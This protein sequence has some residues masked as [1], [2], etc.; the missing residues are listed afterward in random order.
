M[1]GERILND[2]LKKKLD[3]LYDDTKNYIATLTRVLEP[4][5]TKNGYQY[6]A[7]GCNT[8]EQIVSKY[9]TFCNKFLRCAIEA[10]KTAKDG[11]DLRGIMKIV[12][13]IMDV[14]DLVLLHDN[15]K[16]HKVVPSLDEI[17]T[18]LYH[19]A[20]QLITKN[21]FDLSMDYI[22]YFIKYM[23]LAKSQ[24]KSCMNELRR[25]AKSMASLCW[26]AAALLEQ[27]CKGSPKTSGY[28]NV[29]KWRLHGV[30]LDAEA[31]SEA[32]HCLITKAA[33]SVMKFR[34][35]C[36]SISIE[37][38][39]SLMSQLTLSFDTLMCQLRQQNNRNLPELRHIFSLF[40]LGLLISRLFHTM[41]KAKDAFFMLEKL[42]NFI[43]EMLKLVKS[44][45]AESCLISRLSSCCI[46][47]TKATIQLDEVL[48]KTTA[49]SSSFE[50]LDKLLC[51]GHKALELL[52]SMKDV[53]LHSSISQT[54]EHMK[55]FLQPIISKENKD[56]PKKTFHYL[57]LLFDVYTNMLNTE[58]ETFC[59]DSQHKQQYQK[60]VA[61]YLSVCTCVMNI[62]KHQIQ[63]G[64]NQKSTKE[65]DQMMSDC[66]QYSKQCSDVIK[67][68][69]ANCSVCSNDELMWHGQITCS[70][71]MEA[72]KHDAYDR[73]AELMMLGCSDMKQWCYLGK[74]SN[75][76]N[77]RL[78]QLQ[79]F[80]KYEALRDCQRRSKLY[81]E[82]FDTSTT[83]IELLLYKTQEVD[84]QS[85]DTDVQKY[86]QLWVQSKHDVIK[87]SGQ[88]DLPD[89]QKRTLLDVIEDSSHSV[90]SMDTCCLL[91]QELHCCKMLNSR[92]DTLLEQLSVTSQLI[93]IYREE[94]SF[95]LATALLEHMKI[96]HSNGITDQTP[97]NICQEA[98]TF[99]EAAINQCQGG[100]NP[101]PVVA[102]QDTLAKAYFWKG[103][104]QHEAVTRDHG[105]NHDGM[106]TE[107]LE[108]S[109]QAIS[110][111]QPFVL[112]LHAAVDMW[113]SMVENCLKESRKVEINLSNLSDPLETVGCLKT[114]SMLYG[115]LKQ[116]LNQVHA[117][118]LCSLVSQATD[119]TD[120][121]VTAIEA[122]TQSIYTLCNMHDL[123]H[124]QLIM[125]YCKKI[126]DETSLQSFS[127]VQLLIA[128]SHLH[129]E[130][131]QFS[132]G[133]KC[134]VK[135]LDSDVMLG[136]TSCNQIVIQAMAYSLLAKYLQIPHTIYKFDFSQGSSGSEMTPLDA[137]IESIRKLESIVKTHFTDEVNTD[138]K[139][140]SSGCPVISTD[141][142]LLLI[143][144]NLLDC[145]MQ[146]GDLMSHQG[147]VKQAIKYFTDGL[148]L[149][150]RMA[151]PYRVAEFVSNLCVTKIHKG[152]FPAAENHLLQVCH[153]LG[154]V[155]QPSCTITE[156]EHC[157]QVP[158]LIN[159][160]DTCCHV[161]CADPTI[162]SLQIA[163][164][165]KLSKYLESIQ[166]YRQSI[167][168]L[169]IADQ[170]ISHASQRLQCALDE[171]SSLL[172]LGTGRS[173]KPPS[174]SNK[175]DAKKKVS[176]R[177]QPCKL[178]TGEVSL[179]STIHI[180]YSSYLC[181]VFVQNSLILLGNGKVKKVLDVVKGGTDV[182][183][184][185]KAV[186]G[187]TPF[188][189]IPNVTHLLYLKGV[190]YILQELGSNDSAL[191]AL[192]YNNLVEADNKNSSEGSLDDTKVKRKTRG[193]TAKKKDVLP[194]NEEV[195]KVA[196]GRGRSKKAS[197]DKQ[198]QENINKDRTGNDG[199]QLAID[200]FIKAF[201]LCSCWPNPQL[202]SQLCQSLAF[203]YG[204]SEP[205]KTAY[206]L[207]LSLGITL[208][209]EAA[210]TTRTK[211]RK[212][213]KNI[214]PEVPGG[215]VSSLA[216]KLSSIT[217]DDSLDDSQTIIQSLQQTRQLMLFKNKPG[218]STKGIPKD[219]T[220]CT[221]VPVQLP[222]H[223]QQ[224][225]ISR[226]R[227][228]TRP[229]VV[230]VSMP[231]IVHEDDTFCNDQVNKAV[232]DLSQLFQGNIQQEFSDI[233]Q[234]S[235]DSM[236]INDDKDWQHARS[237]LDSRLKSLLER[238]E[239]AWLGMW[240]GIVLGQQYDVN[241]QEALLQTTK[242]LIVKLARYT[243]NSLDEEII[244]MIL[245]S[246]DYLTMSQTRDVLSMITGIDKTIPKLDQAVE[247]FQQAVSSL[248]TR[249]SGR[250][251]SQL[252]SDRHPVIL[253]LGK[254]IQ[255][256]P[257][258]NIPIL[259]Q[260]PITRMPSMHFVL[261]QTQK[262]EQSVDPVNAYFV[263]NPE[264][265]LPNTQKIFQNWFESELKW[266]G[267]SGEKPS[268]EQY[269]SA[270]SDHDLFLYLGHNAGQSFLG[271]DDVQRII[272]RATALLMGCS[273]AK[274]T[275]DGICEPRGM[276]LRYLL[277]GCPAIVGNLWDVTDRDIDRFTKFL[278]KA[279]L[280][281]GQKWSL[282]QF[283]RNA[284]Q[285]CKW[286]YLIGASPVV[287]GV[288]VF[289]KNQ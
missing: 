273:S 62:Y 150:R 12:N 212:L 111:E 79:L 18:K 45:T 47:L 2:L 78:Q 70:I 220:I 156:L 106:N 129:L 256:L 32:L 51:E 218:L 119:T 30:L 128:R 113:T 193:R 248:P 245:D 178:A 194:T 225:V 227:P 109:D 161:C 259:R 139:I 170:L 209:H 171:C 31:S 76:F 141:T 3:G 288:P 274:L 253:I 82:A 265:N 43:S 174:K 36:G 37:I 181:Q 56:N 97:L 154:P 207:D 241:Q 93:S 96:L 23:Q 240:K 168:A 95:C 183:E 201:N 135:A 83:M 22:E 235:L 121:S 189:L 167:T 60:I 252:T 262:G 195:E 68:L 61:K 164:F 14:L 80:I 123:H 117:N 38:D 98:I 166:H 250:K 118:H 20:S 1:E 87:H 39:S 155:L 276:S 176:K 112:S 180:M 8:I 230:K 74:N 53:S 270:L 244:Q 200:T 69:I 64:L 186:T 90:N 15:G 210:Y 206:Y 219:W 214:K 278:L 55:I 54:L 282:P 165:I 236:T 17:G 254:D 289:L 184:T 7:N 100:D 283:L 215:D 134:L 229:I 57:L 196:K 286:P 153:I 275:V 73:A 151:L 251:K 239:N 110:L 19:I 188:W 277:A 35:S 242:D 179:L 28:Y 16:Y 114:V 127:L 158:H 107:T 44:N 115:I 217:I 24:E 187:S 138:S 268:Q 88:K 152:D 4:E 99:L 29:L 124:A 285:A 185:I 142:K 144:Q 233:M 42:Q 281:S 247:D 192:W 157:L 269:K 172:Q 232:M 213:L 143:C 223:P 149:S 59:A 136:K 67:L 272:C 160:P 75:M 175:T 271:G 173:P 25:V 104:L 234:G 238:M 13:M 148:C 264:N 81:K 86:V 131:G 132:E 280:Q 216:N 5:V 204:Y 27:S 190:A 116:P 266:Q 133:E 9:S 228:G 211:I 11:K 41:K 287:Y 146:C 224:L 84:F 145:Q 284:R 147:M 105:V 66:I 26:R 159:H 71:G 130:L 261:A 48:Q 94:N 49:K 208:R 85:L 263:L 199:F 191:D 34:L 182:V 126:E 231:D 103:I 198:T 140:S 21:I 257:W 40:D 72:Y 77:T 249:N 137:A 101:A 163:F 169:E 162:Q 102:V 246:H 221:L 279:W 58:M 260:Y 177:R 222:G 243:N 226:Q 120:T 108:L 91:E 63:V 125:S 46:L 50:K 122:Y 197:Q 92:Y 237:K 255:H 52:I 258:E 6:K 267:V 202:F 89:L 10:I 65:S 203:C 205:T 33:S